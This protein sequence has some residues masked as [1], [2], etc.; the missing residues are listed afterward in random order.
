MAI[1]SARPSSSSASGT[2]IQSTSTATAGH[3]NGQNGAFFSPAGS[4][5]LVLAFLAMLAFF[6][7]HY[8][9]D[10]RLTY[11]LDCLLYSGLFAAG[12]I[13]VFGWRRIRFGR[14]WAAAD[15][16][17]GAAATRRKQQLNIG[18]KPK[19]WDLWI[20]IDHTTGKSME[21]EV[22]WDSIMVSSFHHI[23]LFYG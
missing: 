19:L 2:G 1:Q 8:I 11:T 21:R 3:A 23:S 9:L 20:D 4:P 17:G 7:G 5:P 6:H 22:K 10:F 12:M 15:V 18:E 13:A 16:G 14:A